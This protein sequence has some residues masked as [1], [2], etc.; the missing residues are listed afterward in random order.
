MGRK[1]S[2]SIFL[3]KIFLPKFRFMGRGEGK[4][5]ANQPTR[6]DCS[7]VPCRKVSCAH[8]A[9]D[10]GMSSYER[11]ASDWFGIRD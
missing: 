2:A 4:G 6:T 3:P 1:I 5:G 10:I 7:V 8:A 9:L 11:A